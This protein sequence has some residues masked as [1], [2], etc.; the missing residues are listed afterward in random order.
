MPAN[1]KGSRGE[2]IKKL[3]LKETLA[4]NKIVVAEYTETGLMNTEFATYINSN[5]ELREKFRFDV[6]A[7]HIK[8]AIDGAEIP[9]NHPRKP[10]SDEVGDML[11][12][13]ARVQALEEQVAKHSKLLKELTR[14]AIPASPSGN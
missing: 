14:V 11:G 13:T 3:S 1:I 2:T 4:L 12:L 10:K 6:N 7:N 9:P 8:A 5:P